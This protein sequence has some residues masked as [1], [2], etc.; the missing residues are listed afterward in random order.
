MQFLPTIITALLFAA[1]TLAHGPALSPADLQKRDEAHL[2]ARRAFGAC[3]P[4][5][6][7]RSL[8]S[9]QERRDEFVRRHQGQSQRKE[10]RQDATPTQKVI[11]TGTNTASPFSGIPTC[12]LA[13]DSIQGPYCIPPFSG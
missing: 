2:R 4:S 13:P 6:S 1:T 9:A 5:L 12:V 7:K 3:Q 10:K 8:S 11:A